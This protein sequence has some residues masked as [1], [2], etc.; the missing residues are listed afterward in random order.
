MF[1][2]VAI[3]VGVLVLLLALVA[4]FVVPVA[5]AGG[6][7]QGPITGIEEIDKALAAAGLGVLIMLV[8]EIFKRLGWVPDGQAGTWMLI[9]G[10]AAYLVM[11]VLGV[12]GI[13]LEGEPAQAVIKLLVA[14]AQFALLY[15]GGVGG[16]AA[17]RKAEVLKP[18]PGRA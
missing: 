8:I 11:I 13:S 10:V 14:V 7:A 15:L 4:G 1:S 16:H 18:L 5:L 3:K 17:L 12:F 9:G 6:V 2:R